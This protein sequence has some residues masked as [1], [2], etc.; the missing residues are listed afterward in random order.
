MAAGQWLIVLAV[1]PDANRW[2]MGPEASRLPRLVL[3]HKQGDAKLLISLMAG[4]VNTAA[5]TGLAAVP[6]ICHWPAARLPALAV[7]VASLLELS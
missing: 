2:L 7:P 5:S 6:R 3:S 1:L 4:K